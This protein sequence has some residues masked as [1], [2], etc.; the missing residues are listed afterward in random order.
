MAAAR[1]LIPAL[2]ELCELA[3]RFEAQAPPEYHL[4]LV[5]DHGE[6]RVEMF[7]DL[8]TLRL[9]LIE[10]DEGADLYE[11]EVIEGRRAVVTDNPPY[12]VLG[13]IKLP[14]FREAPR[15]V[16]AR[17]FGRSPEPVPEPASVAVA[18]EVSPPNGADMAQSPS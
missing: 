18:S 3:E 1:D 17:Q 4:V 5:P 15:R 16:G 8:D 12:L 11:I 13:E 7:T 6:H 2:R 9:R 10:I 14:L